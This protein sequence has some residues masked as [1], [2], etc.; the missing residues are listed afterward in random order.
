MTPGIFSLTNNDSAT[1]LAIT[2]AGTVTCDA[3][4]RQGGME[5]VSIQAKLTYG[6]GGTAVKVY[7]QTTLDQGT[8]WIDIA[9][10][11]FATATAAKVVGLKAGSATTVI[12]PT[13]GALADNTCVDGI[14]G[15]QLR[16]KVISTGTYAGSTSLAVRAAIR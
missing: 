2:T 13:D 5:S 6:S 14:L 1:D 12:T 16:L 4:T 9:C 8:T 10:L 15:D 3:I 11:T 7:V